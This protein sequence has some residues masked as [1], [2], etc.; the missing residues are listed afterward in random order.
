MVIPVAR[1]LSLLSMSNDVRSLPVLSWNVRGLGD[2]DKCTVVRDAISSASPMIVCLQESKL[3]DISRFKAKTFLPRNLSDSFLFNSAAGSRGGIVT[4]WDP[5]TLSLESWI[6]CRH[7]LTTVLSSTSSDHLLAVTNV[8]APADH[9]DSR[10]FLED[11]LELLPQIDG[12]WLI[13]GDFNLVRSANEKSNGLV[14]APLV[15]AFNEAILALGVDELPLLGRRF[16]WTNGQPDPIMSRLDR[17]FVNNSLNTVFPSACLTALPRPTSDH[18]PIL[19]S[20]ST[21]IPKSS[22]FR[23]EN[24]W[25][26]HQSFLPCILGS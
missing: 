24:C 7:T 1:V 3:H 12:P 22:V 16:T 5:S 13:A 11:L 25:L 14:H 20:L 21:S 23:F 10:A 6:S 8:Y 18:T 9:R 17:V 26:K 19:A 4:A 2:P 15:S